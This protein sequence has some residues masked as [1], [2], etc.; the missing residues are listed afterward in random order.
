MEQIIKF[1]NS[2]IGLVLISFLCTVFVG[3]VFSHI[4]QNSIAKRQNR[5]EIFRRKYEEGTSFLDELAKL[6]GKRFFW[7]QRFLWALKNQ[8]ENALQ[9]EKEYFQVVLTWNETLRANRNKIRLLVNEEMAKELLDYNDNYKSEK[10][11]SLHY[12]FLKAHMAVMEAKKDIEKLENSQEEVVALNW[13]CNQFLEELTSVFT[14]RALSLELLG[15]P[16]KREWKKEMKKR[17][18]AKRETQDSKV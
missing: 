18:E 14:E 17:I 10:P 2:G 16:E 8:D 1:L 5:L 12:T 13:K 4:L 6:V 3:G 9:K 7:L 11:N 15:L